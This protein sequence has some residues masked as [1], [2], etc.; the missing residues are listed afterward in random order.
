LQGSPAPVHSLRFLGNDT[1]LLTCSYDAT[2]RVWDLKQERVL[3]RG[4]TGNGTN[5]GLFVSTD[6]QQ[7]ITAGGKE[8]DDASQSMKDYGDYALR[9]WQLPESVWPEGRAEQ[10]TTPK[11]P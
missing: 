9:L 4:A 5:H 3:A 11:D 1:F 2:L 6:G 7:V 8:W 10:A